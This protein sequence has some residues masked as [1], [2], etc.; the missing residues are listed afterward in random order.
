MGPVTGTVQPNAAPYSVE[1][2][3]AFNAGYFKGAAAGHW[4]GTKGLSLSVE[5]DFG[6][7]SL[8]EHLGMCT[9]GAAPLVT[10][11]N[12][13]TTGLDLPTC[14]LPLSYRPR[15]LDCLTYERRWQQVCTR[16]CCG[17][18]HVDCCGAVASIQHIRT[19]VQR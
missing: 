7:N 19:C 12:I 11:Y 9:V 6:A 1:A 17:P 4:E 2:G 10:N 13:L 14:A 18:E 15:S 3:T 8:D 16:V 5:P